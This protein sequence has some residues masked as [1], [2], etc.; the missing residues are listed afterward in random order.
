MTRRRKTV[1]YSNMRRKKRPRNNNKYLLYLVAVVAMAMITLIILA[2]NSTARP[3]KEVLP[4]AGTSPVQTE[5]ATV[6]EVKETSQPKYEWE[7]LCYT[8]DNVN[9]REQPSAESEVQAVLPANMVFTAYANK[10]DDEWYY[11]NSVIDTENSGVKGWVNSQFIKKHRTDYVD[12]PLNHAQQDL[13]RETIEYFGLDV[14]EYF[15]YGLMYVESRFNNNDGSS[16]GAKGVMQII[17]ST[18]RSTYARMKKEYPEMAG[19]IQNDVTDMNSNIIMGIYYIKVL[20][21]ELK[22][23]SAKDNATMLLTAYN[24]G[25]YNARRYFKKHGT[26]HTTYSRD[27]LRAAD[28][29]RTNNTWKEGI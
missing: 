11:V 25:D 7:Q 1:Y 20:Q 22:V 15:F 14:D 6:V 21:T 2:V 12:I 19:R 29:I 4:A 10:K 13:V 8:T 18:W 9:V 23:A 28:Y 26:Y 27:V 17:P 24:R 5:E 3:R 16:A